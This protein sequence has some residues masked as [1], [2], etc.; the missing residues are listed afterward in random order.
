MILSKHHEVMS[1]VI[2]WAK[3]NGITLA[4]SFQKEDGLK[5]K[6]IL[7]MWKNGR[8]ES[9][10]FYDSEEIGKEAIQNLIKEKA[11]QLCL[12]RLVL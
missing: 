12:T 5:E 6:T 9:V 8:N 1:K 3:E 7:T 11:F 2:F 10:S 4:L